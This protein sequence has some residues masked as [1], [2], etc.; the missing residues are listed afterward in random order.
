MPW[1]P[2]AGKT[3]IAPGEV[4]SWTFDMA[5]GDFLDVVVE[6]DGI[7]VV[8]EL[9]DGPTRILE[10]DSLE[11]WY[12]E[13]EAAWTAERPGSYRLV[14]HPLDDRAAP[15]SYAIRVD[16]PRPAR[17][18]DSLRVEA[19]REMREATA[20]YGKR[21]RQALRLDHLEKALRLWRDLGERRRE[22]EVLHQM[23]E[24]AVALGRLEDASTHFH[25]ALDLWDQLGLPEQRVLTLLKTAVNDQVLLREE[26]ARTH[27][28]DGVRIA[29]RQGDRPLLQQ[30]L[31]EAGRFF[32]REPRVAVQYLET[33][34]Q[35]AIDMRYPR[36]EM[37]SAYRLGYS[38]DDLGEKQEA[39]RYY[40]KALDL[41]HQQKEP[42]VEA[43]TLNGLGLL[44]ASLGQT[45]KAIGLYERCLVISRD[46]KDAEKE[47]AA[48]NNLAL[49]YEK[50][51]PARARDLYQRTLDLGR[52]TSNREAQAAALSNLALLEARIGDPARALEL[53]D[54]AMALG[55]KRFEVPSLQAKGVA[56]R[57]LPDLESS[58]RDLQTA[59]ELSRQRQ[60]RVRESLVVLELARTVR[61]QGDL[62]GALSLLKSGVEIVESLRTKVQEEE[63]RATF[64][65][66]R[67]DIYG[68][69]IDTLMAL[70]R[71]EPGRG[72][73]AEALLYSERARAR[74]LLDILAEAGADIREK[75]DP[76]LVERQRQLSADIEALEERRLA[77]FEAGSDL[78]EAD[79]RLGAM[80]DEYRRIESNLRVSS[81]RYAA[82]TQPEPLSVTRI[83]G[84][85]LDG[86][87]LL[88]EY[89]LGEERSFLW[90][91]APDRVRSF[92]L[93]SRSRIED[94]ARLYY[95]ALSVH[96]E[97]PGGK[98]AQAR[99]QVAAD[100]LSRMLL[101]PVEG[102]LSGQPLLVV[103]DGALQYVPFGALPAPGSLD[104][105]RRVP[106]IAG[107]EVVS[108]PSASALAVLR[109][110]LGGRPAPSKILAVLAD[111]VFQ[112]MDRRPPA[113]PRET[114]A[115]RENRAGD[116]DPHKLRR[117]RWSETEAKGIAGL[118]PAGKR[119]MA[120]GF[121]ATRA[122][123]T[124]GQLANY[125]MVHF[126][127]HG[128]ID[129]RHPELSSLVLSLVDKKG[130]PLNGFLRLH[131]I[132]N[133]ELNAD[134]VVLSACQTAL[135]QEI[136]GEGLVGLTR[137][138]M[139]AGAARVMSSLWSVD[140]RATSALMKLFYR[141]MISGG[142]SPAEALRR[143]QIDMSGDPSQ[144]SWSS[145]YYWAAFSL[146]GEWR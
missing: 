56:W 67:Q 133:L 129:S 89:A 77:L 117:L 93:P 74:S 107:H 99:L 5:A 91:V 101:Q 70:D 7:D 71:A 144:P 61:A 145:P 66:S 134:L 114:K 60:D 15:G 12:L 142:L 84:E 78:R 8:V 126:A 36:E 30:T 69:T 37:L 14:V 104:R 17:P 27:M 97:A 19:T 123:A 18:Q 118:V 109:R 90:A 34:H 92:E 82:L 141:H 11:K 68:L 130:R 135:G 81:P 75:A 39:L 55:V 45:E 143:A 108:L 105:A 51:D 87:A 10:A 110:E 2:D 63:L 53:G 73:D 106:L 140:D 41:A 40:E 48:L 58:R 88:L 139:Y 127:T 120:L 54:K 16:G 72:H 52:E 125:R 33:A 65:A 124:S 57:K 46:R 102:M 29:Q 31:Y 131:D 9:F 28:E 100:V 119:F 146:Q 95:E 121:D 21:G 32:E 116:V 43:N 3:P 50:R 112:R 49:I 85:I 25:R 94:A 96:P 26:D 76:A 38:Y 132:Y 47:T 35:L 111:P 128:L 113:K 137:G 1:P 86:R 115:A 4:H 13:E 80:L 59:L 98:A 44:Y 42:G 20:E 136:R 6:Q 122:A 64:L 24:T 103:S 83:Q 79:E 138:F 62:S 23:G 22:A